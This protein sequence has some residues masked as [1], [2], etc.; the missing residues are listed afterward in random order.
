MPA[1]VMTAIPVLSPL[2]LLVWLWTRIGSRSSI[3]CDSRVQTHGQTDDVRT[4]NASEEWPG[5]RG[6]LLLFLVISCL[7][8]IFGDS[9]KIT[10][11]IVRIFF[12]IACRRWGR[13][14]QQGA[15][16]NVILMKF[17][18]SLGVI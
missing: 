4:K 18:R 6:R 14:T 15:L 16:A 9:S 1:G 7:V 8:V 3:T 10:C 13:L 11:A 5:Q 12:V 2:M 17:V